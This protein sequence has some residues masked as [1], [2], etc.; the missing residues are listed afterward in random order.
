MNG[1][2]FIAT[3]IKSLA[4]PLV[5]LVVLHSFRIQIAALVG[6]ISSFKASKDGIEFE[7]MGEISKEVIG[8]EPSPEIEHRL[9]KKQILEKGVNANGS[10]KL[11]ANGVI[12]ARKKVTL[13]PGQSS[14]TW[15]FPL[16]W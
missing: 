15:P 1:Y 7:T 6:K 14:I 9:Q 12:V 8:K 16:P 11:Y 13:S 10:Y 5:A 3:L 2:E 4:W